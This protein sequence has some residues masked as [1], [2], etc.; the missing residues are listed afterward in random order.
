MNYSKHPHRDDSWSVPVPEPGLAAEISRGVMYL[1][2]LKAGARDLGY[3]SS[4]VT[5]RRQK[6]TVMRFHQ[7]V[8]R[9]YW[10]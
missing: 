3:Y 2:A 10:I 7:L 5:T 6:T 1:I 8:M 9:F 4:N